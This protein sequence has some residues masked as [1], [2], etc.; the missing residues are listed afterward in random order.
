MVCRFRGQSLLCL[1]VKLMFAAT[2]YSLWQERNSRMFRGKSINVVNVY[3]D[4]LFQV[5]TQMNSLSGFQLSPQNRWLVG[6]WGLSFYVMG[7]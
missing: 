1:V 5:R 7:S 4:I 2:V 3:H 6:S